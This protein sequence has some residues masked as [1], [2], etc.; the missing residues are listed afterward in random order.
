MKFTIE[1]CSQTF[2]GYVNIMKT[3]Y[4]NFNSGRSFMST[5]RFINWWFAWE[6]VMDIDIR[7]SHA[8]VVINTI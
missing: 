2:Q 1:Q 7:D 6:S 3:T 5:P 4:D 8:Q